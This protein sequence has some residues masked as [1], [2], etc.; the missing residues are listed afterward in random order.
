M[1]PRPAPL[2]ER[3]LDDE[4][5]YLN[6]GP[7][8]PSMHGVLRLLLHLR[9]ELIL[10]CDPVIGYAHRAHEKMAENRAW[11]QFFPNSSRV[12]YLSGMIY[13]LAYC[14]AVEKMASIE[15]PE[16]ARVIRVVVSELNRI[17]SHLLWFGTFLLD[18]GGV[19]PFLYCFD[20]REEILAILDRV[21][22]SRLT[23]SYGR[24]GGVS[25]DIDDVF[26][27]R[28][29]SFLER[30]RGRAP[31]YGRL[32]HENVIFRKR[33]EGVG[34]ISREVARDYAVTGPTLR[35]SGVAY[36]VRRAEPYGGYEQFDFEIP[37][38]TS[39]DCLARFEVRM[40]EMEQSC[41]IIEQ[42]L[43]A[44]P[45]GPFKPAKLVKKLKPPA[46]EYYYAV[47]S[48]RGHFGMYMVSDGGDVPS[49]LKLRTPSFAQLSSMPTV[50]KGTMVADTIAILGSI[51]VVIPE[52]DR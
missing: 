19:T 20:D 39:G 6:M 37:T 24:F 47:E 42:A 35:A 21:T 8:H 40:E 26:I 16:R 32:V 49:R 1:N 29:R 28:T 15:V 45:E 50:L 27:E 23:Y 13:N 17:Q 2:L 30:L 12:D 18:I 51:D 22:G 31:M 44:L 48:A 14:Q 52:I 3:A 41:R 4:T 33:C 43:E 36:D 38:R 25:R 11:I 46:G 5:Y 10:D 7:Q 34:V 9:G